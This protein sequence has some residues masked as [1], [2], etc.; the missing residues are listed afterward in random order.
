MESKKSPHFQVRKIYIEF[1]TESVHQHTVEK[2]VEM[3]REGEEGGNLAEQGVIYAL[4][5]VQ[6]KAQNT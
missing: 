1:K 5:C 4:Q 6:K 2:E 3:E